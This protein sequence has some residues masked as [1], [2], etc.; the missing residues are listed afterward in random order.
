M[1]I[2]DITGVATTDGATLLVELHEDDRIL[3]FLDESGSHLRTY[4]FAAFADVR[5]ALS[6]GVTLSAVAVACL[7]QWANLDPHGLRLRD[8]QQSAEAL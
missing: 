1:S 4:S 8:Q 5:G 7:Q 3:R 6:G 2:A